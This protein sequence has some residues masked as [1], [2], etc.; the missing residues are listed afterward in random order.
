VEWTGARYADTP[1]VEVST[2]IAA[3]PERVW[4]LVC[5]IE[6]MPTLSRELQSVQWADGVDGPCVGAQFI[7]HNKHDAIG[8]WSTRSRIVECDA[9]RAFAWAVG[10]PDRPAAKW[11]FRLTPHD[12][13]T[14]LSYWVQL[15]PGPS[16]L[17][18]AIAAMP[19]KEQKIVFSRLRE[20]E[21][22]ITATLAGIKRLAESDTP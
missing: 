6:L 16:G 2:W 14:T 8:E 13:G 17:S 5:D 12:Q 11:R 1:T 20:F 15:G 4:P 10:D 21:S 3:G 7:G 18:L 22:S 9:P 19:D